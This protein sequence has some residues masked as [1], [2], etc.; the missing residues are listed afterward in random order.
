MEFQDN[1]FLSGFSQVTRNLIMAAYAIFLISG[2]N[3]V[4]RT[5][6]SGTVK[7]YLSA[8]TKLFTNAD[9]M[10]PCLDKYGT[11]NKYLKAVYKEAVRWESIPNRAEP[12]TIE[13]VQYF[14]SQAKST[15]FLS[16]DAALADWTVL[17][18]HTGFRISEFGQT[19]SGIY[20]SVKGSTKITTNIDG[21]AKAFIMTDFTFH[22]KKRRLQPSKKIGSLP[23]THTADIKFRFQKNLD[24]GQV[25]TLA[26]NYK[27]PDMCPVQA[28]LRICE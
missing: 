25:I 9:I 10:D 17:G 1:P 16:A 20:M 6:R 26:R 21:T 12:L 8:V 28:M 7:Q 19:H 13:M 5:I 4:C 22:T 3:L 2:Q 11:T 14:V 15:S 24:N 27:H 18:L 23:T